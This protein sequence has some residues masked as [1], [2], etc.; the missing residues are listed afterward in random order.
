MAI[1]KSLA[2][3][4]SIVGLVGIGTVVRRTVDS[5]ASPVCSDSSCQ[6]CNVAGAS[7]DG[8][9]SGGQCSDSECL[10]HVD[11]T[12]FVF[13]SKAPACSACAHEPNVVPDG[14]VVPGEITDTGDVL[15]DMRNDNL[16]TATDVTFAEHVNSKSGM[17]LVDFY[18]DWC[19]PCKVQGTILA[20]YARS[21]PSVTVVKVNVDDSPELAAKFKITGIPAL[22]VFRGD[23][24]SAEHVGVADAATLAELLAP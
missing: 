4:A 20:D 2:V 10:G 8:T 3:V 21:N 14:D 18:A 22:K 19:G 15:N 24:V 17:V 16:V 7:V 6:L 23:V 11:G 9:C 13:E 12:S 1:F 5:K